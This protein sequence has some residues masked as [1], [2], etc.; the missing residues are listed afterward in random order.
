M[1]I[2]GASE[3]QFTLWWNSTLRSKSLLAF[4]CALGAVSTRIFFHNTPVEAAMGCAHMT[5][6]APCIGGS[7]GNADCLETAAAVSCAYYEENGT[8][9]CHVD[10]PCAS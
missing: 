1:A 3:S 5:C 7:C 9:K 4:T 8:M 10:V 6:F 2:I